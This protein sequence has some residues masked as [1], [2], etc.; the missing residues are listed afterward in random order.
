M[1]KVNYKNSVNHAVV[2]IGL[3][4][5]V[6]LFSCVRN[7]EEVIPADTTKR[8]LGYR[9]NS[10]DTILTK[11]G[12][13][14][15]TTHYGI[16]ANGTSIASNNKLKGDFEV[17][18]SYSAFV[19]SG[20]YSFSDQLIFNFSSPKVQYPVVAALLTNDKIYLQDSSKTGVSKN[21]FQR[22]G[23]FHV[24]REGTA[25]YS[26]FRAGEDSLFLDKINYFSE[27]LSIEMLVYSADNTATH[28]T[29]HID[30]IVVIGGGGFVKSNTFDDKTIRIIN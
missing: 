3:I 20:N 30:D 4:L 6:L 7:T 1:R 10:D 26:W 18:I 12:Y 16:S 11:N 25:I 28:T 13:A 23:E 29:V 8:W 17:K 9:Q 5:S 24:K 19:T 27:D 2:I 15:L 22:D 21:T 14:Y